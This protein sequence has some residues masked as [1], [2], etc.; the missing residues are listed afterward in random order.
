[1][2]LAMRIA[3]L[4][5]V[6]F[7]SLLLLTSNPEY[8]I[9]GSGELPWLLQTLM[10]WAHVLSFLVL[11]VFMLLAHWPM[12]RWCVVTILAAYGGATEILQGFV[13]ART[14]EWIDWFQDLGGLAAGSGF[15]WLA[16]ML[17]DKIPLVRRLRV[18]AGAATALLLLLCAATANAEPAKDNPAAAG[19]LLI[20][21]RMFLEPL[22]C[23]GD[24]G[25]DF[26]V[27]GR[28]AELAANLV[29]VGE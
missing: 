22:P 4:G 3:C 29:G 6:V 12:P 8:L 17:L 25:V 16:A 18:P 10:P 24:D 2:Q 21:L 11:A 9:S 7:L 19:G 1:M 28:P 15:C 23:R 5:Y 13:P 14:P 20:P 27:A 26:D